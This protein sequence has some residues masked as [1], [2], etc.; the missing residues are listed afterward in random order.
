MDHEKTLL[1]RL[2]VL[3]SSYTIRKAFIRKHYLAKCIKEYLVKQPPG[4]H[5][6]APK[7]WI[8]EIQFADELDELW[9]DELWEL[10]QE[11]DN[12]ETGKWWILKP[13][14][15]DRGMGLRLFNTRDGL[16]KIFIE[17]EPDSDAEDDEDECFSR[18][19]VITS[20]LRHF[21]IQ[22]VATGILIMY[23]ERN[24]R[25]ISINH[26]CLIPEKI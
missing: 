13:G 12:N 5:L 23:I 11:I 10:G 26:C 14:M 20:Q 3:A 18:T 19:A 25:I 4:S 16:Q 6:L 9:L 22:V 1:D 8:L 15:A 2:N 7:T 17:F 21:V 24:F